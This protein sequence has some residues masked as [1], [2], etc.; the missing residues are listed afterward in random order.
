M[1]ALQ[2]EYLILAARPAAKTTALPN[3]VRIAQG[4]AKKTGIVAI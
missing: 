2:A 1:E 4:K 3:L